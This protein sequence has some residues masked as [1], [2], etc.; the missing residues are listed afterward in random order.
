MLSRFKTSD[1]PTA[2]S[3]GAPDFCTVYIISKGKVSSCRTATRPAPTISR[4]RPK[5]ME[6]GID[7]GDAVDNLFQPSSPMISQLSNFITPHAKS[8]NRLVNYCIFISGPSIPYMKSI[9]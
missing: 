8:E 3:K 1:V 4:F 2:I 5:S 7:D 6:V 9:L